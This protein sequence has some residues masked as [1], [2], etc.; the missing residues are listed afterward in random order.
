M[1]KEEYKKKGI[2]KTIFLGFNFLLLSGCC[3]AFYSFG[4]LVG[5][6]KTAIL[7]EREY[8][9]GQWRVDLKELEYKYNNS[10]EYIYLNDTCDFE[11][12]NIY[13]LYLEKGYLERS[14]L[15]IK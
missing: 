15:T 4:E 13:S 3:F 1:D 7:L 6:T 12:L 14:D 10:K 2:Y 8:D 5:T 11:Q 9:F